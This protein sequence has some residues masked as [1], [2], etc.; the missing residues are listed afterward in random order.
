VV[1]NGDSS[2][3]ASGAET[4]WKYTYSSGILSGGP[5]AV[6]GFPYR[7]GVITNDVMPGGGGAINVTLDMPGAIAVISTSVVKVVGIEPITPVRYA[8]AKIVC[9]AGACGP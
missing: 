6:S 9:P 3:A 1:Y 4:A 8:A 5:L 2:F 7:F